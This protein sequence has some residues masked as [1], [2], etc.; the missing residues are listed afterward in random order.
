[1]LTSRVLLVGWRGGSGSNRPQSG[2]VV[3]GSSGL[4]GGISEQDV[5]Q[6][7]ETVNSLCAAVAT[8]TNNMKQMM[9]TTGQSNIN[10]VNHY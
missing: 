8:L 5:E 10:H 1:M 2:S 6:L 3:D 7:L 4:D 9:E